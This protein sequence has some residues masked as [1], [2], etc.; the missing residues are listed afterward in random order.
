MASIKQRLDGTWRARYRDE[1]G[2][3]HARHFRRKVDAQRWLDEVT[4][5]VVTGAYV[6]P[7]AGRVTFRDYAEAWRA[8][9]VHRESTRVHV[10]TMLRRHA[11]PTFGDR[12]LAS[13]QPSEVQAWVRRLSADLAPATVGVVH[14]IA[15]G[16]FNAAVRDRRIAASPCSGSKLPKVERRQVDPLATERVEALIAAVPERFRALVVLAAGTGM[17]QG[18]CFGLTLDRVDFL[19]RTVTVD[20]QLALVQGRAPFLAPPKTTAS[21]RTIPLPKVVVD[22]LA[23]HVA[24]FP[25]RALELDVRADGGKWTVETAALLF[26][27]EEG[28]PLRRTAFS[29]QVWRPAA[30]KAHLP[31]GAGF[32]ALR[33]YYASLLIRHGESVKTVQAR[34]GH[35]SAAETLDTYSHLWPDSDDRTR[36]AVDGV[37]LGSRRRRTASTAGMAE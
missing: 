34:L 24:A 12:P 19:R 16:I 29:A 25:P 27:T 3:E 6:D 28:E 8:A 37:L 17:R 9:Q 26:T 35:A 5:A 11:Y 33:H 13:I 21:Y 22:E 2:R 18:E 31:A 20:R 1:G 32:H 23:A 4:A 14:R 15:A 30:T 36:D 10:E 7:K